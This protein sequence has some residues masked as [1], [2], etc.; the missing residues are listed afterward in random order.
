[1][2]QRQH[3]TCFCKQQSFLD[4]QSSLKLRVVRQPFL[5]SEQLVSV[6][7]IEVRSCHRAQLAPSPFAFGNFLVLA[8]SCP[9][10]DS[11]S[12]T[13]VP[14]SLILK[15]CLHP[16]LACSPLPAA[17][18][19]TAAQ[20]L[21]HSELAQ[22]PCL[23]PLQLCLSAVSVALPVSLQVHCRGPVAASG[24]STALPCCLLQTCPC[25]GPQ[26]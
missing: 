23:C 12:P 4:Y 19:A 9:N 8:L 20:R 22:Q 13:A 14:V 15:P 21:P 25:V 10:S 1:V 16:S 2:P 18:C 3:Q 5:N 7:L 17:L 24:F 26:P 6:P 11:D